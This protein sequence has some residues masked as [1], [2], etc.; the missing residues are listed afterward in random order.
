MPLATLSKTKTDN[1]SMASLTSHLSPLTSE[2]DT[3]CAPA[4][5]TGGAL[6][7]IRVSG[8]QAFNAVSA[9]CPLCCGAA[10]AN[11]V[12]FTHFIAPVPA[13]S[14]A[15]QELIDEALVTVFRAP[16]SYTGEDSIEISC[17]GSPYIVNKILELLIQNGCR[18]ANPGEFTQRAYLNGKLD[19][20]QAE[21][22][23]D[24]I[25]STNKATHRLAMSQLRGGISTE[26]TNLR[27][28][29]LKL[30]SL[31]E[32]ELDF[33][34]HEDL[35]FADRTQLL[36]LTL[37]IDAH[38]TRL[39]D[40]FHVGNALKNGIPVAI[41]GA[42]NVGKSTLLNALLG[43]ERAIVSDIQGT[44][45]DAIEDTIQ[46]GGITFRFIDT[47]GIRHTDDQIELMGIDRSIAAAQRAQVILMMT[48]PGVPYPD[49]PVRD[50]QTVITVC[51]KSDLAPSC[52]VCCD[53]V[54]TTPIPISAKFNIG[55]DVLRQK[56]LST[57]PKPTDSDI[58][59]TNAR[60]YEALV[61][62]HDHLQRV[63]AGL[64]EAN[65]QFS[66]L[67]SQLPS[68]LVAEDLRLTLDTLAEITGG[69]IT[70]NE[71]L[72]NVF[73]NFCVGK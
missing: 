9:I 25:A 60:H 10:A 2:V 48:Q 45:R 4:T 20:S 47:A 39:A 16:H 59:V 38:I 66:I 52:P 68:D 27:E 18:M 6:A 50:D 34:D 21:A 69:Q 53:S 33:S 56:I 44:T 24:L 62:A 70:S 41:V 55:L 72:G 11:T 37:R 29:L 71:V 19:L 14:P 35:E 30:T 1:S 43:E 58:I 5:A 13:G 61:C 23:A 17:H 63:L 22:V 67:N 46:L 26:L 73:K 7:I 42:P 51:N 12:H 65:S 28:Q 64:G 15:G 36:E 31:L 3:I 40:S 49:I 32:L 8:P 57:A 54:A